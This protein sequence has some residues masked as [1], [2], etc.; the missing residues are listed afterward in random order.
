MESARCGKNR[1]SIGIND[2]LNNHVR[3]ARME[4]HCRSQHGEANLVS[5]KVQLERR[6]KDNTEIRKRHLG[7]CR[8]HWDF[9]WGYLPK[10]KVIDRV[11]SGHRGCP[12]SLLAREAVHAD[13]NLGTI[14]G[15]ANS[16]VREEDPWHQTDGFTAI[17]PSGPRRIKTKAD[18]L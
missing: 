11:T 4:R 7:K 14:E 15:D 13:G 2:V 8:Y 16:N 3:M 1:P 18:Q 12:Y 6:L 17:G 9:D 5:N 10:G